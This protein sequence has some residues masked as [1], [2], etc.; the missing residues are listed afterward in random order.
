MEP[1]QQARIL[2]E[3]L[4]D[5]WK[6]AFALGHLGWGTMDK[7]QQQIAY[8]KEALSLFRKAGAARDI[9]LTLGTLGN[10]EIL[11]GDIDSAKEHIAEAIQLNQNPY[12]KAGI[13]FLFVLGRIESVQGNFEKARILLEKS[14]EL[15]TE[16]GLR[17]DSLWDRTLLGHIIAQQGQAAEAREIFLE[18]AQQFLKDKNVVGV[19]YALEGM[20][21][22]YVLATQPAVA[23]RLIGWADATR[24]RIHD[25]RP[26]LEQADVDKIITACLATMGEAAFSDT[27]DEGK[28]MS[29][30]EAVEYAMEEP[31]R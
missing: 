25:K 26:R 11:S 14:L 31:T 13:H 6:Q 4:G 7:D 23:A 8:F 17:N 18:T 22:V 30:D 10:F 19:C 9:L 15:S 16:L 28:K 21:E 24:E 27:Y 5:T 29:L 2:S 20:A 12:Y 1:M 3:A